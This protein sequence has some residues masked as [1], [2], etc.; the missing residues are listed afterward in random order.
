MVRTS[1]RVLN[2]RTT[3]DRRWQESKR[4]WLF[5]FYP[6]LRLTV[7]DFEKAST[8][9]GWIWGL[10]KQTIK[11]FSIYRR[12][13]LVFANH[14]AAI[15]PLAFIQSFLHRS[16][17]KFVAVDISASRAG[18]NVVRVLKAAVKSMD[19]IICFTTAQREWWVRNVGY[20]KA[21]FI[22]CGYGFA[23]LRG[24]PDS[25]EFALM[26]EKYSKAEEGNYIFSGG[27][28]ARDY[29]TLLRAASELPHQIV[30][31]VGYDPVTGKT[32]LENAILSKKVKVYFDI[33]GGRFLDLMSRARVVVLAMQDKPYSAGQMVLMNAMALGKPIIITRTAGIIDYVEDGKTVLLVE[34]GNAQQLKEK[35]S[36]ISKD[37]GLRRN[38]GRNAKAKWQKEFTATAWEQRTHRI[39]ESVL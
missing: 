27:Y 4:H 5:D 31:V 35:I 18:P 13:D 9:Y 39:I 3:K 33:P 34:P 15:L 16:R 28:I 14:I 23:D 17:P 30:L 22:H 8:P 29:P 11:A 37:V 25:I 1:L 21:V 36:M 24:P 10:T 20:S 32:G 38:L 26:I 12:Y 2:L 7:L 6:D 19:A